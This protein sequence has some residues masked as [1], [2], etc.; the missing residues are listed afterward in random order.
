MLVLHAG[1]SRATG[2]AV[3]EDFAVDQDLTE[4]HAVLWWADLTTGPQ[5][6]SVTVENR[7]NEI[8]SRY[9]PD[10]VVTRFVGRTRPILLAAGQSPIGSIQVRC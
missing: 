1:C 3:E 4:A 10:H 7:L 8:C 9:G 6:Q 2:S 5:G